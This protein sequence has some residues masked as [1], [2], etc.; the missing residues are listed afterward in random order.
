MLG[1]HAAAFAAVMGLLSANVAGSTKRSVAS[2]W[3]FVCYCVGQIAAPLFF[4]SEEAPVYQGGI[5]GMLSS[6]LLTVIFNQLLRYLYL[7]ENRRR[8][9]ELRGKTD[10]ELAQLVRQSDLQGFED[11]TD[12]ANVR[13]STKVRPKEAHANVPSLLQVMF[14]YAL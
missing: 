5:A 8:E 6:F 14:R 11:V 3:V 4:R 12:K 2:G 1:S 10:D 7:R 13:T 9:R